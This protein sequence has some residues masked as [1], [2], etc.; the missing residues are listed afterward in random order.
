M[1]LKSIVVNTLFGI[2]NHIS[3]NSEYF[4]IDSLMPRKFDLRVQFKLKQFPKIWKHPTAPLVSLDM[5][6]RNWNLNL[7]DEEF[8]NIIEHF[9]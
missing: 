2:T 3:H 7:P 6:K 1:S 9:R 4:F 8:Y 5:N